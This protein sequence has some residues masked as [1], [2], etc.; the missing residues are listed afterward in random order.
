[1]DNGPAKMKKYYDEDEWERQDKL[2]TAAEKKHPWKD[3][4]PKVKVV[5]AK[6][7]NKI[8]RTF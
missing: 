5:I 7:A 4:P 1:M 3:A 2:W 6:S 8:S